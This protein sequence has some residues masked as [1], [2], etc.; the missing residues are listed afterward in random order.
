M[1]AMHEASGGGIFAALWELAEGAGVG[2]TIDLRKLP[3]R[4]ETIEIC[5]CCGVNPYELLS[6]GCLVMTTEDGT[7][8]AAALERERIPAAVVG[9]VTD[10]NRRIF[11]NEE[12]IRYMDRP[13]TDELFRIFQET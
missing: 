8:L 1:C 3:V 4:Q 10:E 5:E 13:G 11:V 6:G 12:E 2:L 7:G 9:K